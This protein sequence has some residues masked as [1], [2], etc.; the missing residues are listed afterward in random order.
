MI[1]MENGYE[2]TPEARSNID[3]LRELLGSL[4]EE[5]SSSRLSEH[6]RAKCKRGITAVTA[7]IEALEIQIHA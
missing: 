3:F 6:N 5:Q 4:M 1:Q 7:A 2:Q